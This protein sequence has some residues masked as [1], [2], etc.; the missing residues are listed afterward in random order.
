MTKKQKMY[1]KTY[2]MK[3]PRRIKQLQTFMSGKRIKFLRKRL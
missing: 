2:T 3:S 1:Y